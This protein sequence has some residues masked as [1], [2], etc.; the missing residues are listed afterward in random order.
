MNVC[1]FL[2][3]PGSENEWQI[4]MHEAFKIPFNMLASGT[5]I[6]AA[7]TKFGTTSSTLMLGWL[8][9]YHRTTNLVDQIRERGTHFAITARK[10]CT[11]VKRDGS[12]PRD[13]ERP[14]HCC[15][16]FPFFLSFSL[17]LHVARCM[18]TSLAQSSHTKKKPCEVDLRVHRVSQ[19]VIYKD[20]ERMTEMQNFVDRLQEGYR[21]N[22]FS[23]ESKRK[24]KAMGNIELY[25]LGET[26][27]TTQ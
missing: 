19:D 2:K 4:R 10:G 26:V 12:G 1:G 6:K 15:D 16:V 17:H 8:I 3:P 21:Y 24:L 27:T 13:F 11:L 22:V 20:E 23:E 5:Q 7:I 14:S 25:E 9:V 18:F